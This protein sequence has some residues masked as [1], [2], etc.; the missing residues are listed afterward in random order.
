MTKQW[1]D[2]LA[3]FSGIVVL[4]G[5]LLL[6]AQAHVHWWTIPESSVGER[7]AALVSCILPVIADDPPAPASG[8]PDPG[9]PNCDDSTLHPLRSAWMT[10]C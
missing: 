5:I 3:W 2:R 6:T 9:P 4:G 1:L 10:A 8:I 7:L